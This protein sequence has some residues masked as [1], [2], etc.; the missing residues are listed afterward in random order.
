MGVEEAGRR[1]GESIAW[2]RLLRCGSRDGQRD[3]GGCSNQEEVAPQAEL[4]GEVG[5]VDTT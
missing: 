3:R 1:E 5:G 4:K 2:N